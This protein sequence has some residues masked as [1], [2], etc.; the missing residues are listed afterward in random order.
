MKQPIKVAA[1]STIALIPI[2]IIVSIISSIL[3]FAFGSFYVALM[4]LLI[5]PVIVLMYYGFV[6]LGNKTNNKLL[7][8]SSWYCIVSVIIGT[9]LMC[10]FLNYF[11]TTVYPDFKK[12]ISADNNLYDAY[13]ALDTTI[14]EDA[15]KDLSVDELVSQGL[16]RTK[17]ENYKQVLSESQA[18]DQ[19]VEQYIYYGS[20]SFSYT[21]AFAIVLLLFLL[22]SLLFAIGIYKSH[23]NGLDIA[24]PT[25]I[26]GIIIAGF[27][28]LCWIAT[29]IILAKLLQPGAIESIGTS[30][31]ISL[32][33]GGVLF[34]ALS[35][36]VCMF[37]F[38]FYILK[39]I[40]LF[41]ASKKLENL[42]N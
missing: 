5:I 8:F 30:Q 33:T 20:N 1:Y 42:S 35:Q 34:L 27:N 40:L 2:T 32:S 7:T 12:T 38:A 26:I 9:V 11:Q 41:N 25:G 16:D 18:Q 19:K 13:Y 29:A 37:S 10:S 39:I 24:K 31:I 23:K 22:P 28:I 6:S 21:T 17:V 36:I 15:L 3:F 14:G 4:C